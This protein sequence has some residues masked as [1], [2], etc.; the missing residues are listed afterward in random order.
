M[1]RVVIVGGG[2]SGLAIAFR[3]KQ[4]R[5]D[6]ELVL[7]ESASRCGGKI[8]TD[9]RDGFRIRRA[10]VELNIPCL[11]SLDTTKA[12]LHVM[13]TLKKGGSVNHIPIQEYLRL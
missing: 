7:L 8:G 9:Q 3:L 10:A 5:P 12:I 13:E 11:T 4:A 1:S 2:L 6:L